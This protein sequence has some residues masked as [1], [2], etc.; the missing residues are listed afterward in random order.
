MR[1]TILLGASLLAGCVE[2]GL[3]PSDDPVR[4]DDTA[5]DGE[6]TGGE[7]TDTGP[8]PPPPTCEDQ[9]LDAYSA[10]ADPTCENEVEAGTFTPIVE[11]YYPSWT[12]DS[13]SNNIMMAPAVGPLDDDNGDGVV[14]EDDMPDIVVVTYGGYGT[15]RAV[16][17]DG[18]Y[19]LFNVTDQQL[20][21][22]GAVAIGDIDADG[23]NEVVACT[24]NTVKAF[25]STGALE[26]TSPPLSGHMFGT[27]DAPAIADMDGDGAPE[28]IVGR[29]ILNGADGTL[30]GGGDPRGGA[31]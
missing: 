23:E 7:E 3:S 16:S 31:G 20:Q 19:E 14:D 4:G 29:A 22:Q 15:L 2:T 28:V 11:Y 10:E 26:W 21:G 18:S 25:S 13:G 8:P 1:A 30:R 27:S 24:Y 6:D 9:V 17:G 12:T 5:A